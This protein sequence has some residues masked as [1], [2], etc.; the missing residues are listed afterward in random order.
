VSE[1]EH[2]A[3]SPRVPISPTMV[4]ILQARALEQRVESELAQ[5][6]LSLRKVGL[7]GH[8]RRE[9]GISYSALARRAGIRVQSLQPIIE[10]LLADEYVRAVGGVGQGR[11]AVI[12]LT[13]RGVE[14][15]ERSTAVIAQTDAEVFVGAWD[16]LGRALTG[17][18][19][20]LL[21]ERGGTDAAA[22]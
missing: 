16:E 6:N 20:A 11:A 19:E 7:L 21:R 9:P 10:S 15:L 12:E 3:S 1:P 13:E 14:A 2:I 17:L 4:M 8:L 22:R 5:S 18:G